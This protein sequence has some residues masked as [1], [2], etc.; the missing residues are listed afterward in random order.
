M[1][2][3]PDPHGVVKHHDGPAMYRDFR[4]VAEPRELFGKLANLFVMPAPQGSSC[5]ES[6]YGAPRAFASLAFVCSGFA[7]P[8]DNVAMSR[9]TILAMVCHITS[10]CAS[11]HGITCGDSLPVS[12]C[13]S[14]P[15]ASWLRWLWHSREKMCQPAVG[16]TGSTTAK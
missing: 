10:R 15:G 1:R 8:V 4:K 16:E 11:L 2:A 13:R 14:W 9:Y 5:S 12:C 6:A 7:I 3:I